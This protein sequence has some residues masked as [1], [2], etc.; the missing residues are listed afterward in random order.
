MQYGDITPRTAAYAVKELLTRAEPMLVLEKF[1]Q[2]KPLP[3]NVTKVMKFRRYNALD[4]SVKT[5]VEG[6]TPPASKLTIQDYTITLT[7]YGDRIIIS[8]VISDTHEDQVLQE[9]M[10]ILGE[11][12]AQMMEIMR[13]GVLKGG[14]SVV[15]STGTQRSA[16]NVPIQTSTTTP[17][18]IIMRRVTR[19]LKRQNAKKI[20]KTLGA[21]PNFNTVPVNAAYVAVVH[22]DME[23]DIRALP[24]F[25]PVE[26][27]P[28]ISPFPS[29]LGKCEDIR[30]VTS[31]LCTPFADAGGAA[32][33]NL[34]TS[35]TYADVYPILVFGS[36]AFACT[37]LKGMFAVT[38]TVVNRKASDSDP[39]AQRTHVGWKSMQGCLILNDLWMCRVE[40]SATA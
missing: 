34:T 30:Y 39:L 20:T 5:L 35:G 11:Q 33:A 21:G 38:P 22:P 37:A 17:S 13:Y 12:A 15:Y 3:S 25:T 8:D 9:S 16:V 31:T 27:Y 14:A 6:V 40:C 24:N 29:E 2:T 18:N 4:N 1:G 19:A 26:Q 32:G 36:D 7:Q 10:A 28:Q 23:G